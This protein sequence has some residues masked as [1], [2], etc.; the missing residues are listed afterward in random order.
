MPHV[1][2]FIQEDLKRELKDATGGFTLS[3]DDITEDLKRELKAPWGRLP[4]PGNPQVM[5]IS[6]EN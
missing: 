6:K 5:K 3:R 1:D 2:V 4:S